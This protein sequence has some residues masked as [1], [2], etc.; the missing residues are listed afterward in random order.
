MRSR[1]DPAVG[2]EAYS[3]HGTTDHQAVEFLQVGVGWGR[4]GLLAPGN[5]WERMGQGSVGTR[6]ERGGPRW[7][8]MRAGWR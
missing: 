1:N 5:G 3:V 6:M 8:G 7:G 4:M 2:G